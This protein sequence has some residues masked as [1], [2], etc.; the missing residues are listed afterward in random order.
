[1]EGARSEG[2]WI[3]A[4]NYIKNDIQVGRGLVG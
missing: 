4:V 3:E 1:M 2:S